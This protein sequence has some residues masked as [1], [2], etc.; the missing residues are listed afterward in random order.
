M[1]SVL[2]RIRCE[3]IVLAL[4]VTAGGLRSSGA[5]RRRPTFEQTFSGSV[6][7]VRPSRSCTRRVRRAVWG[8]QG[9]GGGRCTHLARRSLFAAPAARPRCGRQRL[10]HH[11]GS[12]PGRT[13]SISMI[14]PDR[15]ARPRLAPGS[16]GSRR[17]T[18]RCAGARRGVARPE[19][20]AVRLRAAE[21]CRTV[22][23]PAGADVVRGHA[24]RREA[25][26]SA[27]R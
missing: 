9:S 4:A 11:A 1:T 16:R 17:S 18:S 27:T 23:R 21:Y 7:G 12:G 2:E 26:N 8:E 15:G 5:T 24:D 10:P 22:H 25:S 6:T 3:S 20:R 14:E 13:A 19:P